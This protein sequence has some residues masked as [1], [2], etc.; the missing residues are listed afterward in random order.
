MTCAMCGLTDNTGTGLCPHHGV[1]FIDRWAVEN[2]TACDFF[3][4]GVEP[5]RSPA[6]LEWFNE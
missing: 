3:H 2:P 1:A 6:T 4:R 5:P